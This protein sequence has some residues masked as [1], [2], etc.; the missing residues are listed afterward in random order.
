[1]SFNQSSNEGTPIK[2]LCLCSTQ[3]KLGA[4]GVLTLPRLTGDTNYFSME[5][6]FPVTFGV[7]Y[8]GVCSDQCGQELPLRMDW[9][10]VTV[11]GLLGVWRFE[12]VFEIQATE[13]AQKASAIRHHGPHAR[14]RQ[15]WWRSKTGQLPPAPPL[16]AQAERRH[17]AP[18]LCG[19][20]PSGSGP[21]LPT[22]VAH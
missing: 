1:M 2:P 3:E 15:P 9:E 21:R 16:S 4:V 6:R 12:K 5:V 19:Q 13:R 22:A 20:P 7:I 17:Q 11:L 14:R 18:L 10:G 8:C